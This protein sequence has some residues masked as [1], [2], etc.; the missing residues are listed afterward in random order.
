MGYA[1]RMTLSETSPLPS[2]SGGIWSSGIASLSVS[3]M[4]EGWTSGI[5]ISCGDIGE[6]VDISTGGNYAMMEDVDF[7]IS[8]NGWIDFASSASIDGARV[9]IGQIDSGFLTTRWTGVVASADLVGAE[10]RVTCEPVSSLR[11]KSIPAKR[12]NSSVFASITGGA[13]AGV[14]PIAYGQNDRVA[15]AKIPIEPSYLDCFYS[16]LDGGAVTTHKTTFVTAY[17]SDYQIRVAISGYVTPAA[18]PIPPVVTYPST[19][20]INESASVQ[21]YIEVIDGAGK[22]QVRPIVARSLNTPSLALNEAIV[23]VNESTPFDTPLDQSSRVRIYSSASTSPLVA[24]DEFALSRIVTDVDGEEFAVSGSVK[25]DGSASVIDISK[26]F[27]IGKSY[28]AIRDIPG[29]IDASR[30]WLKDG[31]SATGSDVSCLPTTVVLND[32]FRNPRAGDYICKT[33]IHPPTIDLDK[34]VDN[35]ALKVLYSFRSENTSI[36][37]CIVH[38]RA[39]RYTGEMDDRNI[40]FA[41]TCETFSPGL[42]NAYNTALRG[43]GDDGNYALHAYPVAGLPLPLGAYKKISAWVTVCE[44]EGFDIPPPI[45]ENGEVYVEGSGR[46]GHTETSYAGGTVM[47]AVGARFPDGYRVRCILTDTHTPYTYPVNTDQEYSA[48]IEIAGTLWRTVTGATV[49]GDGNYYHSIDAPFPTATARGHYI[50]VPPS[51]FVDIEE[52]ESSIAIA[53]GDIPASSQ[54][55]AYLDSG[56][57]FGSAWA[58]LPLG[59]SNGDPITTAPFAAADLMYRDIGIP[60][61]DVNQASF[62]GLPADPIHAVIDSVEQSAD[63]YARLCEEFNWIGAHD[64]QGREIAKRWLNRVGTTGY[65]YTVLNADIMSGSIYALES[66]AKEDLISIP[67]IKFSRTTTDGFRRLASIYGFAISPDDMD[68]SNYLDH[69][70][71]F[72]DFTQAHQ[73][74]AILYAAHTSTGSSSS[75][76]IELSYSGDAQGLIIDSGRLKWAASRKPIITFSVLCTH[77]AA[78]A[79]IGSRL[80]VTHR[81]Y[82]PVRIYGTLVARYW[83]PGSV[84]EPN[85]NRV[86]LTVMFDP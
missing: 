34:I 28:Q 54:F 73:A 22:G 42:V 70:Y 53:Y 19:C 17:V 69:T 50:W 30:A 24:A 59:V 18:G 39:D 61:S 46:G 41:R 67:S 74:Y 44:R 25:A 6:K 20:W 85:R 65:D 48:P 7:V 1:I 3:E 10:V 75:G 84:S 71:G 2:Y 76:G 38:I 51:Y 43:D 78:W 86:Q 13:D 72:D 60:A 82:A 62:A 56:R 9:E 80:R 52:C 11:H 83:M 31:V 21:Q 57:E 15:L 35:S 27:A 4:T 64:S 14:L 23:V 32:P 8:A 26:E 55:S 5:V 16:F 58:S 29:V 66:S 47:G 36:K 12:V 40:V 77:A 79:E 33:V 68:S 81:R 45:F 63:I 37:S 49:D